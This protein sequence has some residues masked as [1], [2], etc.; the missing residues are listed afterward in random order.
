MRRTKPFGH[1][2][3]LVVTAV[4]WLTSCDGA[5]P[6]FLQVRWCVMEGSSETGGADP[7]GLVTTHRPD[8]DALLRAN[9]IWSDA[10]IGFVSVVVERDGV[11]GVPVIS[12]PDTNRAPGELSGDVDATGGDTFESWQAAMEC[13]RA[14]GRLDP[15]TQGPVVV[16]AR[17]FINAGLTLAGASQPDFD[18]WAEGAHPLGGQRGD[19]LCGEP[20][21]L[22]VE[23]VFEMD[24]SS[25]THVDVGW[26]VI[27]QANQFRNIDHRARALAHELGHVLF[28]GHGN[29]IDDNG[30][31][32]EAGASGPR[33]FDQ[34]CDPLG[35]TSDVPEEDLGSPELE[36]KSLM[37]TAARCP[38]LKALQVEQARAVAS[39]MPGCRGSACNE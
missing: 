39:V 27:S 38:E 5:D 20:R 3:L 33:R 26:L 17:R 12:D 4:F 19:D 30:D 29:G 13:H 15:E 37:E 34:Y 9:E 7:G 36:C 18:L 2:S 8:G 23:D 24:G 14:W 32:E 22:S 11:K 35:S 16:T 6:I 25:T 1:A 10:Q 21:G 28:L 31:G